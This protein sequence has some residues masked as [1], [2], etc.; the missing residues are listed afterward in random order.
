MSK[1]PEEWVRELHMYMSLS[2]DNCGPHSCSQ[3]AI[4]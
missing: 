3:F 1:T 4:G 2:M